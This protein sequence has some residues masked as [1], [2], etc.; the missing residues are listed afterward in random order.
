MGPVGRVINGV[1]VVAGDV[2]VEGE[3]EV[4]IK[5]EVKVPER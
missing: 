1:N 5:V 3:I 4:E 2:E